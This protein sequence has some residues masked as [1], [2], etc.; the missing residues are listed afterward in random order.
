[1]PYGRMLQARGGGVGVKPG[2]AGALGALGSRYGT[3]AMKTGIGHY[4]AAPLGAGYRSF[5]LGGKTGLKQGG[6]GALGPHGA[7]L[8][9]GMSLGPGLTNG[10]GLGLGQGGKRAY[11]A[12]H[13]PYPGYVPY[14]GMNYPAVRPGVS[15]ADL[16]GPEVASLGQPVQDRMREKSRAIGHLYGKQDRTPGPETPNIRRGSV[17]GPTAPEL[18]AGTEVKSL[19][20]VIQSPRLQPTIPLNKQNKVLD[21]IVSQAQ[22]GDR[23]D[24]A[25]SKREGTSHEA[26]LAAGAERKQLPVDKD[27][28]QVHGTRDYDSSLH[29]FEKAK[30]CGSRYQLLGSETQRT[31]R[32][33]PELHTG[34]TNPP[35]RGVRTYQLPLSQGQHV[36]SNAR[37]YL[38]ATGPVAKDT[39]GLKMR[40]TVAAEDGGRYYGPMI[41]SAS[42]TQSMSITSAG[43]EQ[44]A[45]GFT[46][47]GQDAKHLSQAEHIEKK[48]VAS[49]IPG[50]TGRD[51]NTASYMGGAGNY[52][53]A[54]M[55]TG[56]YGA[57]LG[58]GAYLGGAAG[59]LG[60]KYQVPAGAA[61]GQGGYPQGVAGK[62]NGYGDGVTGYHAAAA[63]NG[64]G[65][66]A[67]AKAL[68]TGYGNGYGDG[69][70]AGLDYPAELADGA[71]NKAGKS[72]GLGTGGYTGQVQGA[73]GALGAGLESNGG[74]YGGGAA[75]LPYG[76]G[77]YPY[78][79]Q[80][81]NL[82]AQGTKAANKYG[83]P[84]GYGAQQPGYGAQLGLTQDALGEQT[85]KYG[86]VNAGLGNGYKG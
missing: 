80:Q 59:K 72:E 8:G 1:M 9:T 15:A 36:R 58:Q 22:G 31:Q 50:Q 48:S 45:Q 83:T 42:G 55:G 5:G 43:V 17:L 34:R 77:G 35:A 18:H 47:E 7:S 3:K 82:G 81:L 27:S 52:L 73:Y 16:G 6:Y 64:F 44:E 33:V 20:P 4:P 65:G 57:G 11:G 85:G 2:V 40:T 30:N 86:G 71:Q 54:G 53:G 26:T 79:A 23:S 32:L 37:N 28:S 62:S 46:A 21:L 68:S 70:G 84:T 24:P 13:G 66:D 25:V 63:G 41:P 75:Q 74:K 69:Y 60:D 56:G 51:T 12:G 14:G 19:D 39:N 38:S 76:D 61:L 29:Q 67:G 10:L 78:A 49:R